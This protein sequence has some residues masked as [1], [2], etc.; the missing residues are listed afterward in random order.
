MTVYVAI[1]R[2]PKQ[3]RVWLTMFRLYTQG[4]PNTPTC[5]PQAAWYTN[6]TVGVIASNIYF[7]PVCARGVAAGARRGRARET[8]P[9]RARPSRSPRRSLPLCTEQLPCFNSTACANLMM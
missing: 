9:A 2:A 7:S 4:A 1:W 5:V 8:T 3:L 6:V